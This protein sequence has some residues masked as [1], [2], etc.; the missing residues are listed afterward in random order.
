MKRTKI[1][2][3]WRE[4]LWLPSNRWKVIM[5]K[6]HWGSA[7]LSAH[8]ICKEIGLDVKIA[9]LGVLLSTGIGPWKKLENVLW[10]FLEKQIARLQCTC[11]WLYPRIEGLMK[12][13]PKFLCACVVSRSCLTLCDPTDC[14]P[15]G[16]SVHGIFQAMVLEW[17]AIS[18]SKG[19]SWPRDQTW[20]SCIGR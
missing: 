13:F 2:P 17:V 10:W 16:S 20:V 1:I 7:F 6:K 15:P 5:G 14:C 3:Q 12:W 4:I 11:V 8:W 9:R 18:S 19:S